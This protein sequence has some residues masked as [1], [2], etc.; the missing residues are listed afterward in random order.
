MQP[1]LRGSNPY[2]ETSSLNWQSTSD[3]PKAWYPRSEPA[4][5][6]YDQYVAAQRD[7]ESKGAGAHATCDTM[8]R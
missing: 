3:S 4:P 6:R 5:Q 8:G 2:Y 1:S 7:A